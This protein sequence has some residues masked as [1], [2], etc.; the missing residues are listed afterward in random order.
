MEGIVGGAR[1]VGTLG[2]AGI[3]GTPEG[4]CSMEEGVD[5]KEEP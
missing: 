2:S 1:T 3:S 4:F 5:G